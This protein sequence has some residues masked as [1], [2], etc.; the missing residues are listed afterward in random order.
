[1]LWSCDVAYDVWG[2]FFVE[3]GLA[4]ATQSYCRTMIK[5]FI[6]HPPSRER[7][8]SDKLGCVK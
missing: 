3:F 2:R 7:K 5:E 6:L 1:M 8:V 4:L